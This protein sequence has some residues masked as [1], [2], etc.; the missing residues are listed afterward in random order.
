M[1]DDA[2]ALDHALRVSLQGDDDLED[3]ARSFERSESDNMSAALAMSS[4]YPVSLA[5]WA[6]TSNVDGQLRVLFG[7]YDD[8]QDDPGRLELHMTIGH[9]LRVLLTNAAGLS[10][11]ADS[12]ATFNDG[13]W[14]LCVGVFTSNNIACYLDDAAVVNTAHTRVYP[15]TSA[16]GI[17]VRKDLTIGDY[18]DG[19]IDECAIWN[20]T[21]LNADDVLALWNNGRGLLYHQLSAAGVPTPTNYWNL[22]QYNPG[23]A[24]EAK[25]GAVTLTD[26]GTLDVQGIEAGR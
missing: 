16:V 13:E 23:G 12:A 5:A 26:N 19:Q 6:S 21:A 14:H 3:R 10:N 15:N 18:W 2:D 1:R 8:T 22:S 25:T 24:V 7:I 11:N 4:G 9:K 20:G 17:G